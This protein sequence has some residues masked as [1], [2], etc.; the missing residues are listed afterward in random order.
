M[1]TYPEEARETAA[2]VELILKVAKAAMLILKRA[3]ISW[4][5]EDFD[6]PGAAGLTVQLVVGG[7]ALHLT[8]RPARGRIRP[9]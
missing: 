4:N 3:P 8:R 6:G 9:W 1:T 5:Q 2:K 7:P